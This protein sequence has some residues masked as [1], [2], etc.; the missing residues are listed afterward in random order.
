M[1]K[2]VQKKRNRIFNRFTAMFLCLLMVIGVL[3]KT[4][5]DMQ[6]VQGEEFRNQS[7]AHSV[8]DIAQPAPRGDIL[9]R[10]GQVL[11]SSMASYDVVYSETK[12]SAQ[13]FY[14]IMKEFFRLL[15]QTKE[16]MADTFELKVDP[17]YAFEF[18]TSN[19]K[20]HQ[21]REIRF[22]KDRNM[23]D[24]ILKSHY[25][26]T[27]G[28]NQL[29][30]LDEKEQAEMNQMLLAI[31]PEETFH[32]L[33]RYHAIYEILD[34]PKKE[35][36]K[37]LEGSDAEIAKA[38]LAKVPAKE[39]RRYLMVRDQVA[40]RVYQ[41]NK[42]V[43]LAKSIS[44]QSAFVFMQKSNLLAGIDVQLNPRRIYPYGPLAAHVVG[45]LSPI[46]EHNKDKYESMGY[47]INQDMIG[48]YGLEEA[49][50]E[51]LKGNKTITTVKVDKQGRTINELFKLEGYPG[52]S[53]QTSLDMDLQ[54]TAEQALD[55]TL[56]NLRE[57]FIDHTQGKSN[58]A[59][60]GAVV[61]IE[62]KTGKVLAMASNPSFDPNV[63]VTPGALT[64]GLYEQYFDPDLEAFG[65]KLI[66]D[67]P[68]PGKTVD[69]L[70]PKDA[71]GQRQDYYD[72]YPKPFLNYA[73]QG[74]S[75]VGSVYK[76]FT[77]LAALQAGVV[78]KN[79]VYN[80]TGLYS[81]PELGNYQGQNN[82]KM[83]YGPLRLPDALKL[84][85]NVFF[86]EMGWRLFEKKGL[87][88]IA[89]TAWDMGLG[90]DPLE[91]LHSTTGIEI[92]ENIYGNVFNFESRKAMLAR[93]AYSDMVSVLKS[94]K[95]RDGQTFKPLD[96]SKKDTDSDKVKK[97]KADMEEGLK[98]FWMNT[99]PKDT[100]TA[101]EKFVAIRD[102]L[103]YDLNA[104][105]ETL[106][107]EE[108]KGMADSAYLAEQV[109]S[110]LIFDRGSEL[111]SPVNLL[112]AALGQGDAELTI[113]QL[114]N[115]TATL[116]NGG[117]RYRTSLIQKVIDPEGQVA[118]EV[119]PEIIQK[120]DMP[121]D[122]KE[123]ILEGMRRVN[124][125]EG[126]TGYYRMKGFPIPTAGKTGTAQF[127]Q[128]TNDNYFGR[129]Q[130]GT[131]ITFA[132]Y[133]DPEIAIAVIGYDSIHGAY[134]IPVARAIL[135][136]Y[137]EERIAKE[138]PSY[139]R[140]FDYQLHPVLPVEPSLLRLKEE[141]K[142][143]ATPVYKGYKPGMPVPANMKTPIYLRDD[144]SPK[145]G[146]Q[147]ETEATRKYGDPTAPETPSGDDG[148]ATKKTRGTGFGD[149]TNTQATPPED[150]G[151]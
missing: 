126:G 148:G 12:D 85:S 64:P 114:A 5:F 74:L 127:R 81:R 111:S 24:W 92:N 27:I 121:K 128:G 133:E 37:L 150:G 145:E 147:V 33:I 30:D 136:E 108:Q 120:V 129:H 56:K 89:E 138:A 90:Y 115:A 46:S 14:P 38:V 32:Y 39:L 16:P 47:D 60:R 70:F 2:T 52:Y 22:K 36:D 7:D 119:K 102:V 135:E 146:S 26:K 68:I 43:P 124:M 87:N 67:L 49:F 1:K 125:E 41:T 83:P 134:L 99:P 93:Y 57:N 142:D 40:M 82:N 75:P 123:L 35:E 4:L 104:L 88:G 71:N 95:G 140:A 19:R 10:N 100:R 63:F 44:K 66:Q 53:V 42:Q 117:T 76:P 58:N 59:T 72:L 122:T 101:D 139:L 84:S 141:A 51:E 50:E 94:G 13:E 34:L 137:F 11:A 20:V 28:K 77:S 96:V 98:E 107:A 97:L 69:D 113:L 9:D 112:N 143:R 3:A 144:G 80:D 6:V 151:E 106:P 78:D 79:F 54:Y 131:Y 31:T 118:R 73:T 48:V 91:G 149:D 15:D 86:M 21:S 45:Y 23:D 130:Y 29:S 105:I 17:E 8:K 55:A 110:V 132:P 103:D 61:A 116:A 62:V 25:G 109:A 65:K 18:G